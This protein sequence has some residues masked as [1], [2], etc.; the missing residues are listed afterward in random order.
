MCFQPTT[1]LS[2]GNALHAQENITGAI[3]FYNY[4][5]VLHPQYR[6]AFHSLL[7]VKCYNLKQKKHQEQ[8]KEMLRSLVRIP[9]IVCAKSSVLMLARS[10][11]SRT[12]IRSF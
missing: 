9:A 6:E 8:V 10:L 12:S 3:E 7:V 5:M 1:Y 11:K 2:M 4:A